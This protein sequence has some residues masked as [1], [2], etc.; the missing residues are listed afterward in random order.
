MESRMEK[1]IKSIRSLPQGQFSKYRQMFDSLVKVRCREKCK[2][3]MNGRSG[4]KNDK[5]APSGVEALK[6]SAPEQIKDENQTLP[7]KHDEDDE[8]THKSSILSLPFTDDEKS[9]HLR[10]E[11]AAVN[12]TFE[13]ISDETNLLLNRLC[14]TDEN[15]AEFFFDRSGMDATS[16][17]T[18]MTTITPRA[19][20]ESLMSTATTSSSLSSVSVPTT[21][22]HVM[23][24]DFMAVFKV[25]P[26]PLP[27]NH[28]GSAY[29]PLLKGRS[30][31]QQWCGR[32]TFVHR[33]PAQ[34]HRRYVHHRER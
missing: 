13:G 3:F 2:E 19:A 27:P 4:S 16:T 32:Q 24:R 8:T 31:S 12:A 1:R 11:S 5:D 20:N 18:T 14:S 33:L 28:S 29:V 9:E 26:C 6:S 15:V 21:T 10:V 17:P 7:L 22:S 34:R 23:R 30:R 25:V